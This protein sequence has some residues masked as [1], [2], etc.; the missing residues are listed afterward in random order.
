MTAFANASEEVSTYTNPKIDPRE[1]GILAIALG[2]SRAHSLH[3]DHS[4]WDGFGVLSTK[5]DICHLINVC[6]KDLCELLWIDVE[7]CPTWSV[8]QLSTPPFTACIANL[9]SGTRPRPTGATLGRAA[10]LRPSQERKQADHKVM[11]CQCFACGVCQT[12]YVS[13]WRSVVPGCWEFPS[14][15]SE[16]GLC[17]LCLHANEGFESP[18]HS[19]GRRFRGTCGCQPGIVSPYPWSVLRLAADIHF[20]LRCY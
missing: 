1:L 11:V 13:N 9:I 10:L 16:F 4:D 18:L 7:E 19:R 5:E 17:P 15:S 20:R 12:T 6:R 14:T 8:C 3:D 2:G